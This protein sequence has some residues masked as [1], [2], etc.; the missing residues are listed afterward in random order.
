[1]SGTMVIACSST[2]AWGRSQAESV[3]TRM[4]TGR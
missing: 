4:L 1:V 2:T 3:T